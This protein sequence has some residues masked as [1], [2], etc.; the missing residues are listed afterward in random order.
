MHSKRLGS[1]AALG[2]TPAT[3]YTVPNAKRTIV[4]SVAVKNLSASANWCVIT[5]AASGGDIGYYVIYVG[6]SGANG[7]S[8]HQELWLVLN[9]TD[10]I[11]VFAHVSTL[12]VIVSGAELD[13]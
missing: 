10:H 12:S 11:S 3:I 4:K 2:T 1:N 6:P 9:A 13:L 7:D 5:F 8:A